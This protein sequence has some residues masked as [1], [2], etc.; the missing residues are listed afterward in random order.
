MTRRP[1]GR[2]QS[3]PNRPP[4]SREVEYRAI[5]NIVND[6][7]SD[8][9][10]FAKT[11]FSREKVDYA[12]CAKCLSK[13]VEDWQA[14]GSDIATWKDFMETLLYMLQWSVFHFCIL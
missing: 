13:V 4:P 11:Y 12:A 7:C 9:K 1:A 14:D 6:V 10:K 2:R 8:I 3:H 5:T